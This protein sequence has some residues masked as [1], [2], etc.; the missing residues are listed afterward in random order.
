MPA[1]ITTAETKKEVPTHHEG[2]PKDGLRETIESIVIAFVL[3]FLFRTF[4]A[5]A[6]V[7]PTGSMAPTLMGRH[8]DTNCPKCGFPIK[9][10]A[11]E[12]NIEDDSNLS[13]WQ[14]KQQEEARKRRQL[15]T[16]VC[17]NCRYEANYGELEPENGVMPYSYNGDR[18]IVSKF[19]YEVGDPQRWDVAV[20]RYPATP[21]TN[22]IKRIVGLPGETLRIDHGD[23]YTEPAGAPQG[24]DDF[25]IQRKPPHKIA[26]MLQTVYDNDY[27][28]PELI[29]KGWPPHWQGEGDGGEGSWK[30]SEDWRS[31][32]TSGRK[33]DEIW[34]R[35]KHFEPS[36]DEWKA[37]SRGPLPAPMQQQI[38]PLLV[39]DMY[40]YNS[41]SPT[42]QNI[43]YDQDVTGV[44]WVGDLAIECRLTAE[45]EGGEAT[46]ELVESGRR[47]QCHFDLA[48]GTATLAIV[49]LPEFKAQAQTRVRAPGRASLRFANVDDQLLL[50]VNDSLVSFDR[51]TT[52]DPGEFRG[53]ADADWSPA[54]IAT[55]GVAA[56]VEHLRLLRDIYYIADTPQTQNSFI[57]NDYYSLP[58]LRQGDNVPLFMEHDVDGGL[59]KMH[60]IE[61]KLHENQFLA[62]GDNSPK[63]KD[64]RLWTGRDAQNE[65]EYYVHRDLLVGKAMFIYWPHAW[66]PDWAWGVT[67]RG[68]GTV[69]LPFYPNVSRMQFIR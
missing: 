27:V 42:N 39:S 35:Y 52:Y 16:H 47:H 28:L 25:H 30:A 50:W 51:P 31:Y 9:I 19:P 46:L 58:A 26:V 60:P 12:E 4:E 66:A 63:S 2:S 34:L 13:D 43:S 48:T 8:Y 6:F 17:P 61:F 57:V 22:Y 67:V 3:A 54:G 53:P 18:I 5:E 14:R 49:G 24:V 7:I 68:F 41:R 10:G 11:S 56:R 21:K 62:L 1:A 40:A 44:H 23:I 65:L 20:F 37:L 29:A 55:K 36:P 64:S 69:H 32:T 45:S 33:E 38:R 59:P 15:R